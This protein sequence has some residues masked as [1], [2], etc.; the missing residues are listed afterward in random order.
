MQTADEHRPSRH[1][2]DL[3]T[4]IEVGSDHLIYRNGA[5]RR[6]YE[7]DLFYC[8]D[9]EDCLLTACDTYLIGPATIE[10]ECKEYLRQQRLSHKCALELENEAHPA[11]IAAEI[12]NHLA[13]ACKSETDTRAILDKLGPGQ[14]A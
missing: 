4:S 11:R 14:A 7:I 12:L 9:P 3:P 2:E 1:R 5:F 6:R 10:A 8:D 13:S